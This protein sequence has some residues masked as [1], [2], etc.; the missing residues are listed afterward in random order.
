MNALFITA[1]SLSICSLAEGQTPLIQQVLHAASRKPLCDTCS[2]AS[3]SLAVVVGERLANTTQSASTTPLP[4]VL[5]GASVLIGGQPV[6]LFSVSP[7]EILLQLPNSVD[8][9]PTVQPL[10]V[11]SGSGTSNPAP[12]RVSPLGHFA[13]FTEDGAQCG[14]PLLYNLE[15]GESGV[16]YVENSPLTSTQSGQVVNTG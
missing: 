4:T 12:V 11:R 15:R 13:I 7:T 3:G 5:A 6:P 2:F 16:R 1:L 14:P 10:V 8:M 9:P